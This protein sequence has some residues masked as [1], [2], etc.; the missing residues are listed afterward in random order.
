MTNVLRT[1]QTAVNELSKKS[2][3][4]EL[5]RPELSSVARST[6]VQ[7][8][9]FFSFIFPVELFDYIWMS[10]RRVACYTC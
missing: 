1:L 5:T 6:G 9:I 10:S 4:Q 8:I 7:L 3:N 2:G